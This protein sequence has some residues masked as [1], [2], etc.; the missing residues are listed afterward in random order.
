LVR[1]NWGF[2]TLVLS[3]VAAFLVFIIAS[4]TVWAFAIAGK[5]RV[6]QSRSLR[7][8][9]SESGDLSHYADSDG[10]TAVYSELG[11]LRAMTADKSP[12]TVVV[13]PYL[14]YPTG[15]VPFGEELSQKKQAMRACVLEWFRSRTLK[16]IDSMGEEAVKKSLLEGINALLALGKAEKIYF[17]D[18]AAIE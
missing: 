17:S 11:R 5:N 7:A 13:T 18:Y 10:K 4:G 1:R 8:T 16:E 3:L 9:S 6:A 2:L 12:I 14:I 15:D